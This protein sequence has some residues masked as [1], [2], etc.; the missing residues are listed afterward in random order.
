MELSP[1]LRGF[2]TRKVSELEGPRDRLVS[3]Q[4][5]DAELLLIIRSLG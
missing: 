5:F 4:T 3:T 2:R 1:D